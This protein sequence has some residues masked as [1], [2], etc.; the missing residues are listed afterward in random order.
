LDKYR[1]NIDY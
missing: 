1:Q